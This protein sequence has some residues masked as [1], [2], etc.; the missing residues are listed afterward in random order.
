METQMFKTYKELNAEIDK[1]EYQ[2][3]E[4]F[5]SELTEE[6]YWYFL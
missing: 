2:N 4:G 5:K 3:I 6:E 1:R